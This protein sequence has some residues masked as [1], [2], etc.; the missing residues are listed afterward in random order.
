MALLIVFCILNLHSPTTISILFCSVAMAISEARRVSMA[1]VCRPIIISQNHKP[2]HN[3]ATW[4]KA[5]EPERMNRCAWRQILNPLPVF[6]LSVFFDHWLWP[7]DNHDCYAI[8]NDNCLRQISI[9]AA[10][11]EIFSL[12]VH[13]ETVH[14]S[15]QTCDVWNVSVHLRLALRLRHYSGWWIIFPPVIGF[16]SAVITWSIRMD[17]WQQLNL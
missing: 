10:S 11:I 9:S 8:W 6:S 14:P 2:H 5:F 12:E 7:D 4:E 1:L 17:Q 13:Q 15:K 16:C 3:S